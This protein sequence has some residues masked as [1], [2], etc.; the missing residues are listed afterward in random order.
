L[1][2]KKGRFIMDWDI[3]EAYEIYAK[4]K[5]SA[6]ENSRLR[7]PG[8]DIFEWLMEDPESTRIADEMIEETG[9]KW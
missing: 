7:P 3:S 6:V 8:K 1:K 4:A 5:P 2:L 9:W